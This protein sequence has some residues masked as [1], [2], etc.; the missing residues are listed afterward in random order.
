M[1][2][3]SLDLDHPALAEQYDLVSERQFRHGLLLIDDLRLRRGEHVLDIGTG[4][5]RLAEH[6]AG[7]VAPGGRFAAIDPLP[8]R[9]EIARRR[10]A[11]KGTVGVGRAEDLSA[12]PDR[13]FDAV[14]LNSVFHWL[15]DKEVPLREIQR[16]LRRGGR[17]GLSTATTERPHDWQRVVE[18]VLAS[19]NF[20][21]LPLE[22]FGTPHRVSIA[23]L[24]GQ[25]TA[26]GLKPRQL[27]IRTFVDHFSDPAAVFDFFASSS[28]G[29]FIHGEA[30]GQG[31]ALRSALGTELERWRDSAGI[32]LER[33]LIFAVA[34]A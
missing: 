2:T 14:Y 22:A 17:V 29:N 19:G 20:G 11:G 34:D 10:L 27:A 1:P 3:V 26:A 7:L 33:H 8:L 31:D 32:R 28:F 6:V 4:T 24:R 18:R 15:P 23:E 5:G 16:V 12:F 30:A 21:T 25:F 9:V 13:S